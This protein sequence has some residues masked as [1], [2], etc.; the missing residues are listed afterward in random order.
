M[1][2]LRLA[3]VAVVGTSC[4]GKTTLTRRLGAALE[5]PHVE[6][7]ALYWGPDWTPEPSERFRSR[8]EQ[9]VA[10]PRW[11]IDGN[12]AVVRDLVWRNATTLIW[13][14]YPFPLVFSRALVR[15]L[16]RIVSQEPVLAGNRESWRAILDPEWIP[17]WVIRTY[18]RRRREYP[19]LFQH[20]EH[21]HLQVVEL[22]APAEAER[23][24]RIC[25]G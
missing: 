20:P 22:R 17:W 10:G 5:A 8:V 16:G 13:L 24:L 23:L 19:R 9:A 11:V 2:L 12:Y 14:D 15:T 1:D 4:S 3:R 6:L 21:A 7:D 25:A 18:R